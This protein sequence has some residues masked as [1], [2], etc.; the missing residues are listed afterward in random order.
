MK[1]LIFALLMALVGCSSIQKVATRSTTPIFQNASHKLMREPSW[2]FFKASNPGNLKFMEM[3]YYSDT[4]NTELLGLL[5][6]GYAG[7][8]FGVLET[9][10]FREEL[11][12]KESSKWKQ[13]AITIYTKALDYGLEYLQ[14]KNITRAD[15]L[16]FDDIELAK[17]LD[18]NLDREDYIPVLYFAQVWGS[19]INLQ[20]DN[21]ALVAQVPKVKT[22][23]DWICSK[24]QN[25]ENGVCDMFFAQYEASR[26]RMLGGDPAKAEELYK[27]AMEKYPKNLLIRLSYIQY[28]VLPGF[29]EGKYEDQASFL[30]KEFVKFENQNRDSLENKSEYLLF[31]DLNLFNAIAKKRFEIIEKNKIKIF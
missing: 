24:D 25:I 19:L 15:L 14:T 21:V 30:R 4:N 7:Y 31:E 13:E 27:T 16:N 20:K 28:M 6:K 22:L 17:R 9:L 10:H 2:E 12:G 8:A 29:E 1:V 11:S 18:K 23:F 5:V 26:P 3:I